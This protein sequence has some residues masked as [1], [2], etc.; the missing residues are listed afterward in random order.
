MSVVLMCLIYAQ[1]STF[2]VT[3]WAHQVTLETFWWPYPKV[4]ARSS[5]DWPL[6]APEWS[7]C[8]AYDSPLALTAPS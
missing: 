4:H 8:L 5:G 2:E 3:S 1:R 6:W 7:A